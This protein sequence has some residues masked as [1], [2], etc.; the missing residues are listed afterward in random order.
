MNVIG[1]ESG[2]DQSVQLTNKSGVAAAL[3]EL[4]RLPILSVVEEKLCLRDELIDWNENAQDA[5]KKAKL[6]YDQIEE[7]YYELVNIVDLKSQGRIK[8]CQNLR[9]SKSVDSEVRL[10][11]IDDEKAICSVAGAWVR[12]QYT[13]AS[14]WKKTCGS[15]IQGS[16]SVY[17]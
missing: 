6:P 12:E 3:L 13:K 1:A 7:L 9:T 4:K 11:A 17:L 16:S 10:F 15:I 14:E 8:L 2:A 5:M